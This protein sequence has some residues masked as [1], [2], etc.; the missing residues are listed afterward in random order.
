M[1]IYDAFSRQYDL[2]Q[3]SISQATWDNG[4]ICEILASPKRHG[5]VFDAGAG[6]GIGAQEL[7]AIGD[8][9]VTSCDQSA[10]MLSIAEGVSD[11]ILQADLSQLPTLKSQFDFIV[12]GFDALNYLAPTQLGSFFTWSVR[13]LAVDGA[14]LFDYS[15][16]KLLRHSWKRTRYEYRVND[17]LLSCQHTFDSSLN[18]ADILLHCFCDGTLQWSETHHQYSLDTFEIYCLAR[19][20]GLYIERV[21]NIS[22]LKFSPESPTHLYVLAQQGGL[23][24]KKQPPRGNLP[25]AEWETLA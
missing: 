6:T 15:S 17:W 22:D 9:H 3:K 20:A 4:I 10:P 5:R 23:E 2:F 11:A 19:E 14:L 24:S 12:S 13:H 16:P 25:D 8:F 7:R 21:R 18:R 1:G